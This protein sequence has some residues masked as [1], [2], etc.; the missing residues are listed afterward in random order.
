M[1]ISRTKSGKTATFLYTAFQHG[2]DVGI[3]RSEELLAL[4]WSQW[5]IYHMGGKG[6]GGWRIAQI[7]AVGG[8]W[9][10]SCLSRFIIKVE[11][12]AVVGNR[13]QFR[14]RENVWYFTFISKQKESRTHRYSIS[15]ISI[16]H[17]FQLCY[18][19]TWNRSTTEGRRPARAYCMSFLDA[20]FSY[21]DQRPH[22]VTNPTSIPHY[23]S[24]KR[25]ITVYRQ[26][27][28]LHVRSKQSHHQKANV[29]LKKHYH[30]LF[31]LL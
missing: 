3:Y 8:I 24:I 28:L 18:T 6:Q 27:P 16:W 12:H 13:R 23:Q 25:S 9:R 31:K 15:S 11:L 29:P 22:I 14:V 7:F 26:A 1:T 5:K 19:Y 17:D 4:K 21:T 10:Y 30:M 20:W 2:G